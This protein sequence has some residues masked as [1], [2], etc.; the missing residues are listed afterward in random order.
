[1]G[2]RLDGQNVVFQ[3][4]AALKLKESV[5]AGQR[6]SKSA[7]QFVGLQRILNLHG[8]PLQNL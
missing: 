5:R 8:Q 2:E 4:L 3:R 7:Y 1:V 6:G